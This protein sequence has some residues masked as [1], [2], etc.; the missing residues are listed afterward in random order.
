MKKEELLTR[1]E[2]ATYLGLAEPTL[3]TWASRYP[4][5]LPYRKVGRRC[6]YLKEDLDRY[7][8]SREFGK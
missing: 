1:I 7:I 3:R 4:H 8:K 5:R 6:Q 2:A